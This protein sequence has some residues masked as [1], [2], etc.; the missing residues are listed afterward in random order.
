METFSL[1]PWLDASCFVHHICIRLTPSPVSL[2]ICILDGREVK[3]IFH[4][5][6][7][8]EQDKWQH[9]YL[10]LVRVV[11]CGVSAILMLVLVRPHWHWP[12]GKCLAMPSPSECHQLE[13]QTNPGMWKQSH[14]FNRQWHTFR[15]G[16]Y[17]PTLLLLPLITRPEN[18]FYWLSTW[19]WEYV[20]WSCNLSICV[21]REMLVITVH[22]VK[23]CEFYE[24]SHEVSA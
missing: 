15:L 13:Y 1:F 8:E 22:N 7:L 6:F 14:F 9:S 21:L 3:V 5:S 12:G 4:C 2:V 11:G 18:S 17:L 10:Q 20:L 23:K 24:M 19:F 16:M